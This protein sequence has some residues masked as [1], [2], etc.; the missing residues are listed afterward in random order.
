[1]VFTQLACGETQLAY[2]L[3][4]ETLERVV[5]TGAGLALGIANQMMGRAEIAVGE[6]PAARGHLETAVDVDRL[7]GNVY[8]LSWHLALLGTLERIDG[9]LDAA[10]SRGEEALDVAQRL[11]SGWMQANAERLLGRLALTAGEATNAE[12]YAHNALSR[13]VTKNSALNI[14]ECLDILA[15][16]AATQENFKEA[17]GLLGAAAAGRKQLGIVRFPPEPQFWAGVELTTRKALGD[18][19]YDAA[20][21]ASTA[22]NWRGKGLIKC[23]NAAP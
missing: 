19:H 3:A 13:L 5:E 16:I 15:A 17:A 12:R 7:S 8:L 10:H 4:G 22:R 1:M 11:G 2:S 20:F 6:L 9:N 23:D 18:D 21:S 14:P